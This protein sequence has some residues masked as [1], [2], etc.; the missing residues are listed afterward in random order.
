M[1][2]GAE[3]DMSL[4]TFPLPPFHLGR[5]NFS[6]DLM[7]S[8]WFP[9]QPWW[10]LIVRPAVLYIAVVALLRL[11]GKRQVA[12]LGVGEL[13]VLLLM[14]E[15]VSNG[16]Q[17]NDHSILGGILAAATLI[18]LSRVS[19]YLIFKSKSVEKLI[20]GEPTL[21]IHRGRVIQANVDREL[22][23]EQDL[24]QMLR[25]HGVKNIEDVEQLIL[26]GDGLVSVTIKN[27]KNAPETA[28]NPDSST[29]I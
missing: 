8:P 20:E 13:V 11:S 21:L 19:Q 7:E 25:K 18:V 12:H 1:R 16:L 15:S 3:A 9:S 27:E 24:K 26:E 2:S 14:S 6:V 17:G 5:E 10:L 28:E 22:L 4:T 23:T 29:A